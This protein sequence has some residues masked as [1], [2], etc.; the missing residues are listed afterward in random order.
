MSL[1]GEKNVQA[2]SRMR[3]VTWIGLFINILLTCVKIIAGILAASMALVTDG[4]HSLSDMITDFAV[5]IGAKIGSKKPDEDH[6]YGH[7]WAENFASIF[8]ALLLAAIATG[9]IIRATASIAAHH[10]D[11][12]GF[13]VLIIAIISIVAK[14]Y[15]FVITRNVAMKFSSSMLYANAWHHRSD[16]FSSIAVA[17]GAV[18]SML[19]F[20]YAD[21]VAAIIV[22]VMI[23]WVAVKILLESFGQFT[24]RAVDTQTSKQITGII[25]AQSQIRKWHKLRT[26]VVGRELFMDLHILVDPNLKIT[27]AHDIA[28]SLENE[29]HRQIPQPVNITVHIEP[30]EE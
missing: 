14:E 24:A 19:G 2:L 26:R 9:M 8:I 7:G 28:E 4:I 17:I 11:R 20:T 10:Y 5:I 6:P 1:R 23:I 30:D 15:C 18:A 27:E 12:I 3:R 16:A 13:T 29:I 21:Q 22:A 25:A